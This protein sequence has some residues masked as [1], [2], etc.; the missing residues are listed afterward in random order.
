MNTKAI[1]AGSFDPPTNGHRWVINEARKLFGQVIVAI[2]INPDK[3][4]MFT[5]DERK[6]ML[7]DTIEYDH[8]YVMPFIDSFEGEYLINYAKRMGATHLIRGVR[9]ASDF[10]FEQGMRHV[11]NDLD[12]DITTVFL[13]PPR[14]L[15]EVSSSL[16]KG[17]IG[18]IGW[19][20]TIKKW[21]PDPVHDKFIERFGEEK[22]VLKTPIIVCPEQEPEPKEEEKQSLSEI[23]ERRQIKYMLGK[24]L[25]AD[26]LDEQG[27]HVA[28]KGDVITEELIAIGKERGVFL[29]LSMNIEQED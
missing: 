1:Y 28:Y 12:P 24:R 13:I 4:P 7:K 6:K 2:G 17:L 26:V 14:D 15:S 5:V 19:R 16:V 20:E 29:H 10:E 9:S 18:P 8:G 21:V 3:K 23:F 25:G 22:V 11:N 27:L